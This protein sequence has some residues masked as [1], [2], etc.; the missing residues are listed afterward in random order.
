MEMQ[1][2]L[3]RFIQNGTF[4]RLG[5]RNEKK[6]DVR[7]IA[8]T[9]EKPDKLLKE[10]RLRQDLLYRLAVLTF[11][12]PPLRDRKKD[13]PMLTNLFV[14]RYNN[15]LGKKIHKISYSVYDEFLKYPWYGN[16]RELENVIA[17]GISMADEDEEVLE[18]SHVES[19]LSAREPLA[20]AGGPN[21]ESSVLTEQRTVETEGGSLTG[22]V[23]KFESEIITNALESCDGNITKA[24]AK[25]DIPRQ[26]LSRK[27]KD[28][29]IK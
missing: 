28:L 29:G 10:G 1:A 19:R 23:E 5:D 27:I 20:K 21:K 4:R 12:I 11:D 3:L 14:N 6:V 15:M 16:V 7:I 26:T 17:F 13:I 24:A 9:N 22:L 25:L 2:K 18:L 8:T